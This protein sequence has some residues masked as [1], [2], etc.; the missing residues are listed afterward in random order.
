MRPECK[1]AAAS[2]VHGGYMAVVPPL[3]DAA[4]TVLQHA[5]EGL[6]GTKPAHLL[7]EEGPAA[8]RLRDVAERESA[9]LLVVGARGSGQTT[10]ALIGSVASA[11]ATNAA[12]P[13]VIVPPKVRP[14]RDRHA[15]IVTRRLRDRAV[16]QVHGE[17]TVQSRSS[18]SGNG[19][20][21]STGRRTAG[22]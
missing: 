17:M 19:H 4:V 10:E 21:C 13:L 18:W 1:P 11:L 16:L 12:Q 9:Q 15:V 22:P 20:V 6:P 8:D 14:P 2:T 7:V 3:Q 5:A